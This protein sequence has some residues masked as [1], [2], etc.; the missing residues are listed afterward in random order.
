M[1]EVIC[2]EQFAAFAERANGDPTSA[3]FV[4]LLTVTAANAGAANIARINGE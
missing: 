1:A 4:G 2:D 3:P